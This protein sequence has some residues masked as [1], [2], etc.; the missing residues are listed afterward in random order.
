V[1]RI[2]KGIG[3]K[4]NMSK[5]ILTENKTLTLFQ[6]NNNKAFVFEFRIL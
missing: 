6:N 2:K 5:V 1:D 3:I 4:K